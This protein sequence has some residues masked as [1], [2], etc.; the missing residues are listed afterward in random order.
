M[1]VS[2]AIAIVASWFDRQNVHRVDPTERHWSMLADV[3]RV[4][5][6]RGPMLMDAHLA[7]L[8]LEH[9]ATLATTDRDFSRF[10][11]LRTIDPTIA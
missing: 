1:S 5:Q 6:A 8:G 10:R 7:T 3:A 2:T 4:G 9:G 11:G